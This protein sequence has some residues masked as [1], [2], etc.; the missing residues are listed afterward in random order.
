MAARLALPR[1]SLTKQTFDSSAKGVTRPC[2]TG[3]VMSGL[4]GTTA[5]TP[6]THGVRS[7]LPIN[8]VSENPGWAPQVAIEPE[9][10]VVQGHLGG[11]ARASC[12]ERGGARAPGRRSPTGS[13]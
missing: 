4:P 11:Q 1:A 6:Q 10:D 2:W 5:S 12:A 3:R 9:A 8:Q 13:C 7:L